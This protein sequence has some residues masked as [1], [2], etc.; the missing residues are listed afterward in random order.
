MF[1]RFYVYTVR[2]GRLYMYVQYI[3]LY[4]CTFKCMYPLM[5]VLSPLEQPH[6]LLYVLPRPCLMATNHVLHH[7]L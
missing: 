2:T 4:I 5:L 7:F 6:H 3:R 1:G